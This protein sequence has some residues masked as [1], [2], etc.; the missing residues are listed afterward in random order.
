M[1]FPK[2][3]K[4]SYDPVTLSYRRAALKCIESNINVQS[5]YDESQKVLFCK[6]LK[7][8]PKNPGKQSTDEV[9]FESEYTAC[10]DN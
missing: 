1:L 9:Q 3:E 2:L 4:P 7:T 6:K 10:N 5:L 8:S